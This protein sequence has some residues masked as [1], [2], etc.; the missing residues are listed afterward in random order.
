MHFLL[1]SGV[2]IA[3]VIIMLAIYDRFIQTKN[4]V[5]ANFP[6]I[7]RFRYL[8]HELRP[9]VRQYFF[10]DNDF[11]NRIVIDWILHVSGGKSGYFSFDKFDSSGNL[12]NGQYDM[13]H[14]STP[15]NS[16]EMKPKFPLVG[17]KRKQPFQFGSYIYRS[18]MSL[19]ALSFEA[20][21]AMS[22]ACVDS[23]AP[24]NTGEGGFAVQ[25]I[26]RVPFS[27]DKKYFKY[28]ELGSIGK[29]LLQATPSTRLKNYI[30]DFFGTRLVEEGKYDLYLFCQKSK[31]YYTIDWDAP[32]DVFPKAGELT[33]EFGNVIFQIGSGLYGLKKHTTDG[34]IEFNWERFQK[35]MSFCRAIEI[36]LAQGAKQSGGILKAIK[37]TKTVSEIRGVEPGH[38]LI[39]PNRFPFYEKDGEKEFLEFTNELSEKSGGKPVGAKLVISDESNIEPLV[40]EMSQNPDIALDFVTIDGGDGGSGAAPIYLST[41]FGKKIYDALQITIDILEKYNIRKDTRVFAAAKLYTPFMSAKA[42]AIGAD[43]IGN[44]RSIMIAGGCIR[45]GLCSGDY[46]NCPVGMATMKK[47]NRRAYRQTWDKKV[48]QIS[49]FINAHNKGLIQ[50]A[51]IAGLE[52]PHMLEKKHIAKQMKEN[53]QKK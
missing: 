28:K 1:W 23:G 38:D 29:I 3:G 10:D 35:I 51:S 50:V 25:H 26:P 31:T 47:K 27:K 44:A 17:E 7:G 12:H 8:A 4:L 36:K 5:Y 42:L 11:V 18:A 16:D 19:G 37:N 48:E 32:L 2:I 46:G 34:S 52:S 30:I 6:V 53:L 15:L 14:S 41:L 21:A 13:I 9:F 43:A 33:A 20:T 22:A 40:K 49:N 39:S 24:F 45:A